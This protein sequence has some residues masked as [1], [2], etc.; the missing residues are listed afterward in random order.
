MCLCICL[1]VHNVSG[2]ASNATME[3]IAQLEKQRVGH[4]K[5]EVAP[6]LPET[7][8]ML[9]EFYRPYNQRLAAILQDRKFLWEEL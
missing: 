9:D 5:D 3:D 4:K 1:N 2:E 7:Q 6:M 8:R